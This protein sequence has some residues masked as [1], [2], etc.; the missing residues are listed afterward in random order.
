MFHKTVLITGASRGI[1]AR[2]ALEFGRLGWNVVVN[3]HHSQTGAEEVVA[4]I[5]RN[6]IALKANVSK[7]DDVR[8]MLLAAK[9]RFLNI[10]AVINN[11]AVTGNGLFCDFSDAK[12]RAMFDVNFFGICNCIR[13]V[14]PDMIR[15][16]Q[17]KIIN[18]SSI[19]GDCRS[20][21]RSC[22]FGIKSSCDRAY[23]ISGAGTWAFQ[24]TSKLHRAWRD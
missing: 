24:Y 7:E 13:Q 18:I 6:A 3:Y 10:D 9:D 14:L 11:A 2:M 16:K 1:G 12:L 20:F 5:G 17:G 15:R 21:L 22:L 23:E 19:W 8:R 4:A